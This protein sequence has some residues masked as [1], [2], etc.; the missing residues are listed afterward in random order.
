M[1]LCFLLCGDVFAVLWGCV[2]CCLGMCLLLSGDVF[3]VVWGCVC[4][5][6]GDVFAVVCVWNVCKK[7]GLYNNENVISVQELYKE[8][9]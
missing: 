6:V 3:A 5:C 1:G 2:C 8:C 4:C 7:E 9:V